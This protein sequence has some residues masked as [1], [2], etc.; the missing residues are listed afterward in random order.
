MLNG[1]PASKKL[2]MITLT[3]GENEL[4]CRTQIK[5]SVIAFCDSNEK[6]WIC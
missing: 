3:F 2:R 5:S 6:W 4:I 1:G